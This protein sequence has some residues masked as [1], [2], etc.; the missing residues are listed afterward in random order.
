MIIK[1]LQGAEAYIHDS[2]DIARDDFDEA[3]PWQRA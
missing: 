2:A 3:S 1:S